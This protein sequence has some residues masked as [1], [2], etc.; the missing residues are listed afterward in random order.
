MDFLNN[1]IVKKS[2]PLTFIL[3]LHY[4]YIG[5]NFSHLLLN[6]IFNISILFLLFLDALDKYSFICFTSSPSALQVAAWN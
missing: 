5:A 1:L 3:H 2:N 4:K 6:N